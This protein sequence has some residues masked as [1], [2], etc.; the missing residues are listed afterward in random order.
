MSRVNY[1]NFLGSFHVF[2]PINTW[3]AYAL[4][5][6]M[7]S[8]VVGCVCVWTRIRC[9]VRQSS[10]LSSRLP[11]LLLAANHLA[12]VIIIGTHSPDKFIWFYA[13]RIMF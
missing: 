5:F 8:I 13:F 1:F 10:I 2:L 11:K 12:A 7:V 4:V 6:K 9:C 3:H